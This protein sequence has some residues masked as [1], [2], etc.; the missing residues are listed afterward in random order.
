MKIMIQHCGLYLFRSLD[1]INLMCYDYHSYA[2][3][4]PVTGYNS[5][6]YPNDWQK[7]IVIRT[8][9]IVSQIEIHILSQSLSWVIR[10][11]N[12]VKCCRSCYN[13]Y[14][15]LPFLSVQMKK[16][17]SPVNFLLQYFIFWNSKQQNYILSETEYMQHPCLTLNLL[18]PKVI[19]LGHHYICAV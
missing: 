12:H 8:G 13:L 18:K 9:N 19:N 11:L 16:F 3:Y 10:G 4:D 1:F 14:S 5:P 15:E 7:K 6:L 17:I 2:L